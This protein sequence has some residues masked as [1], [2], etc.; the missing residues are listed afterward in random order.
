M[1]STFSPIN[2]ALI[3]RLDENSEISSLGR[4]IPYQGIGNG[5]DS[6][7][8]GQKPFPST[9]LIGHHLG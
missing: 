9:T 8:S 3:K 7:T 4:A 2:Y 1:Y 5:F 6:H